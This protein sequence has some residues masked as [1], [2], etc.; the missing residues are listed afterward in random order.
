MFAINGVLWNI[1]FVNRFNSQ[2]LRSDGSFTPGVCDI[3]T[4]TVY[5][6]DELQGK[7]KQKVITHEIC[8]CAM[9]SY[10]VILPIEQEEMICDFVATYGRE[11]I[12][13]ADKFSKVFSIVA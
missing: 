11:I 8:H 13:L 2:L 9:A 12:E 5:I 7:F 6:F 10:G 4:H 3:S 1:V